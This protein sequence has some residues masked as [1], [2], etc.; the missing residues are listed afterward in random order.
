MPHN[1]AT[2]NVPIPDPMNLPWKRVLSQAIPRTLPA[3]A[4]LPLQGQA[5]LDFYYLDLGN[6]RLMHIGQDGSERAILHVSAGNLF[7]EATALA[8]YDAPDCCFVATEPSLIHR[9]SGKLLRNTQFVVEFPD[10]IIN[11]MRSQAIKNL[12]MHVSLGC[13]VG[14]SSLQIVSRFILSLTEQHGGSTSFNPNLSH[15]DMATLLGL[16]RASVVRA[17]TELRKLGAIVQFTRHSLQL[18]DIDILA[19]L[20]S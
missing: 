13:A 1:P 17:L 16:H 12:I 3:G 20:S 5:F 10:L 11:L 2:L 4:Y 9:F 6:L 7:N 8:G 14:N 18:G 19:T 15:L